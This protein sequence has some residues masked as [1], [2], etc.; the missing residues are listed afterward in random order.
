MHILYGNDD[1]DSDYDVVIVV[2]EMR[3]YMKVMR[4]SIR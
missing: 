3:E 4:M 1:D 2:D